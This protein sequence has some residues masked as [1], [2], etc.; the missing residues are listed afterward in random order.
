GRALPC[1]AAGQLPGMSF[2]T[3]KDTSVYEAWCESDA[4]NAYRGFDWMTS[5][6]STCPEKTKDFGGCRCQAYM[7]TGDARNADPVCA[8]SPHK[9]ALLSEVDAIEARAEAGHAPA[10]PLVFR[11]MRN[12]RELVPTQ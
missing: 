3:L 11:N 10:K 9:S 12:S 6:C 1:H 4:F 7:L 8:K 2:P 5:P